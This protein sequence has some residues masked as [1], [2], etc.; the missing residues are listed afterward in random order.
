MALVCTGLAASHGPQR[1]LHQISLPCPAGSWTSL[2][3][4]NGAGKSTLLRCLAGLQPIVQG[5]V[6]LAG[7][8][9]SNWSA[10]D[11][12]RRL[13]WLG[14]DAGD[15]S[16]LDALTVRDTIALGRLPHQGWLG[17][18]LPTSTVHGSGSDANAID[19]AMR[20]TDT[21]ALAERRMTSLSGGERQRVWLARALAV[22]ADVLLLDE[23][24]N[25]L[26]APHAR[27]LAQVLR[28]QARQGR[29]VL[30]AV[31][32]LSLALMADRVAVLSQGRLLALAE[33]DD[34]SLHRAIESV[35]DGAIVIEQVRG[36][37]VAIPQE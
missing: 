31:H 5:Q 34:P 4:P 30:S 10:R 6:M 16:D 28:A 26:D 8:D 23:P 12:A 15:A 7:R 18:P 36:R 13:A 25:H 14:Q 11:R 29:T 35:F 24:A 21:H 9:V 33:R 20:D 22:N 2:V 19:Q 37:W 32:E 1:V 3:G 27:L 17:W